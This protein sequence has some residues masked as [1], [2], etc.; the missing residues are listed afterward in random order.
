M[1]ETIVSSLSIYLSIGA[2]FALVFVVFG[3][4]RVDPAANSS[5]LGFRVLCMP[6]C[7]LLWPIMLTKWVRA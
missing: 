1:T 2:V 3:L 6:G 7:V 5:T 4:G